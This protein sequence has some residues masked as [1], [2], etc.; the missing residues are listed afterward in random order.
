MC[1]WMNGCFAC[2]YIFC[3]TRVPGTCR[4]HKESTGYRMPW[5]QSYS[6]LLPAMCVLGPE[7]HPPEEQYGLSHFCLLIILF[8]VCVLPVVCLYTMC[9]PDAQRGWERALDLLGLGYR[10]L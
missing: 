3:T 2:M 6:Q 4:I 7:C 1:A 9:V 10:Q 8:Y 5:D